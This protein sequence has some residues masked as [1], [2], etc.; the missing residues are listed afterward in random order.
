MMKK[1][2]LCFIFILLFVSSALSAEIEDFIN[3][4]MSVGKPEQARALVTLEK[5]KDLINTNEN[6][7]T[8]GKNG[9]TILML[10]AAFNN[11][12]DTIKV[13]LRSGADVN[14]TNNQGWTP[15]MSALANDSNSNTQIIKMLVDAGA[16][17]SIKNKN[18]RTARDFAIRKKDPAIQKLADTLLFTSD[19]PTNDLLNIIK[20]SR[21]TV[22]QIEALINAGAD[23]NAKDKQGNS[24]LMQAAKYNSNIKVIKTLINLGADVNIKNDK[25]QSTEDFVKKNPNPLIQRT[26]DVLKW[27]GDFDNALFNAITENAKPDAIK[28]L[29]ELGSNVN[30]K[31]DG[32]TLLM[33]AAA[34][35]SYPEV[36]NILV[37]SGI[38]ID[39]KT[40]DGRTALTIAAKY[41]KNPEVIRALVNAGANINN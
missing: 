22:A 26:T 3:E 24:I 35:T 8:K 30:K 25:G 12:P 1:I 9:D 18:G 19:N 27:V 7:N 14:V 5:I 32:E 15:L 11:N 31:Y 21:T 33:T 10:A 6:I 23:I 29:I 41:N 28:T 38:N 16:D 17:V 39:E 2:F 40:Y 34:N 37:N 20:D 36:I 4:V 13:L